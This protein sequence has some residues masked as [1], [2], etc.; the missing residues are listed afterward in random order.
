MPANPYGTK[1][2]VTSE[3]ER[4]ESCQICGSER[5]WKLTGG[6]WRCARCHPPGDPGRAAEWRGAEGGREPGEDHMAELP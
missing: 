4:G 3:L 5:F 1:G 2:L 6:D